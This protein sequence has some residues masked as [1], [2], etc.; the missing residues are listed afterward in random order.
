MKGEL[1]L[2]TQKQSRHKTPLPP[3]KATKYINQIASS[4]T[5]D[6]AITNH[7]SEKLSERN[8]QMGDAMMLMRTGFIYNSPV[9]STQPGL[10]KYEINGKTPNSQNRQLGMIVIPDFDKNMIKLVTI[11]WID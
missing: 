5:C 6:I 1:V 8:L 10:W 3:A 7:F 11:F 2:S 9:E 4:D